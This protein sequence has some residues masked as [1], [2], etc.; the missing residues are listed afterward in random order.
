MASA[1]PLPRGEGEA[2]GLSSRAILGFLEA[3][4][5]EVDS[6]HGYMLLRHGVV[7]AEGARKPYSL[8]YPHAL[9]SLSKSFAS[10]AI[11]LAV[12]EGRLSVEDPV[13]SFFPGKGPRSPSRNLEAMRVR[14]LLS[15]NTGH[16]ADTTERIMRHRDPARAF[17]S[18]PVE[19]EPGS[20]FLYNTGASFMLSAIVQELTGQRLTAYLKDRL[21]DPLGIEGAKWDAHP[22]GVEFGG[23]GLSLKVEDI[24]RFGLLYLR[25]GEWEGRRILPASWVEEASSLRSDNASPEKPEPASDWQQGYGYQFWRCRHA[26][27]RGDGAFGQ[28]C[29]VMPEQDAVL[30]MVGGLGDLQKPLDLL[31]DRLLPAMA[32]APLPAD[33]AAAAE[34]RAFPA[35]LELRHPAASGRGASSVS[36][37]SSY[38]FPENWAGLESMSFDFGADALELRYRISRRHAS[39]P[40]MAEYGRRP[41]S[42]GPRLLRCGYGSWAEGLSCLEGEGPRPVA[43]S[44]AWTAPETFTMRHYSL[45][46]PFVTT[47][48]F[49]FEGDV[50]RVEGR[51]NVGFGPTELPPIEGRA[52]A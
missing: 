9:Y 16:E 21:F 41:S 35:R 49:R 40:G 2:R 28:Y 25:K 37:K 47:L 50:V 45:R 11:G 42:S 44:G 3:L 7:V 52:R 8:D 17:L 38:L 5:A 48:D 46:T 15:M 32:E 27:F 10:T 13:L 4:D 36:R 6:V 22:C 12:A 24:A 1:I 14:H 18:L 33:P 23:F 43:C 19:R 29:V 31:W 39:G 30:A 20:R 51:R 34:L 26:C